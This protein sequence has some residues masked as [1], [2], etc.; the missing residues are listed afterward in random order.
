MLK[1]AIK[2]IAIDLT[3]RFSYTGKPHLEGCGDE[4]RGL[5]LHRPNR[6]WRMKYFIELNEIDMSIE[7][8][9]CGN[10]RLNFPE[11]L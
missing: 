1:V 6:W 7:I 2:I 11:A 5:V 3:I 10:E 9:W 8:D 4:R